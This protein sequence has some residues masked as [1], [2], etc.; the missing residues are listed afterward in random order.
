M[1]PDFNISD[2]PIYGKL[3]LAPMDGFSDIPYR[4]LCRQSGSAIS[5]TAFVN[6]IDIEGGSPNVIQELD[7]LPEERPVIFQI[8]DNSL[9]RLKFRS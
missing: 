5:Y 1:T 6:A 7:Y 2:I 8:F 4:S 3:I 9:P